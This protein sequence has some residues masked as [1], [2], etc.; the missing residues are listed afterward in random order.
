MIQLEVPFLNLA[1]SLPGELMEQLPKVFS[2]FPK[3]HLSTALW[4]EHQVVFA[5][6]F[7]VV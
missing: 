7:S 4:D 2:E 5:H 3:Q 1:L 6:P